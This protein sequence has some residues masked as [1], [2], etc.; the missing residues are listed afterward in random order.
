LGR[1]LLQHNRRKAG[2]RKLSDDPDFEYL[3]VDST[4]VRAHQHAAGAKKRGL[5]I[6]RS[7]ARAV[8]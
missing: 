1:R 7:V 8:A 4:I 3:I 5:K 2:I 6:R